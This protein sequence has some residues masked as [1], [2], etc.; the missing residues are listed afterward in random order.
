MQVVYRCCCGLDVHKETVAA[1]V[2]WAEDK[3]KGRRETRVFD[4]CTRELL[5]L[6]DWLRQCGVTH[7]VMEST[8]VY[9][10]L[11]WHI[12]ESQFELLLVNGSMSK[13]FRDARRIGGI[14]NG[15]RSCGSMD[16]SRAALCRRNRFA[17][18]AI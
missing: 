10:K 6:A 2:L 15:W 1:C 5:A 11:V 9:G 12:L 13:R 4:T 14:V 16:Y 7:A 3:G 17:S 8:G 18:C